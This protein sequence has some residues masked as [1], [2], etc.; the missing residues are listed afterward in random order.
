MS[1]DK[2]LTIIGLVVNTFGM[3]LIWID[4]QAFVKGILNFMVDVVSTIGFSKD[5]PID[6]NKISSLRATIQNSSRLKIR[7]FFLVLVGFIIQIISL[8]Y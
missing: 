5:N 1:V 4:S 7:G 8:L 2:S 3:L 6:N